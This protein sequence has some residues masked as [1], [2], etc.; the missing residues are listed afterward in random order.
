MVREVRPEQLRKAHIPILVTELG[1]VREVRPEQ[2]RKAYSPILVTPY[3]I[4]TFLISS[5]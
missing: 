1:M 2:F 4:T 5:L 3:L